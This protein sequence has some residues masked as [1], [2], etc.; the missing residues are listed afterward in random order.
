MRTFRSEIIE[1]LSMKKTV[2]EWLRCNSNNRINSR[3][4][5]FMDES[6]KNY[7]KHS[8]DG[9]G[10]IRKDRQHERLSEMIQNKSH[11]NSIR[12]D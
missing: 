10:N 4:N 6:E 5:A 8:M 7:P 2:I 9:D 11:R 3:L 1:C 12:K